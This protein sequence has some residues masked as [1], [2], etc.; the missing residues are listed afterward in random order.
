MI[1]TWY[2]NPRFSL[3]VKFLLVTEYCSTIKISDN[4][5]KKIIRK[6]ANQIWLFD[7]LQLPVACKY[8][9]NVALSNL[10]HCTFI[11]PLQLHIEICKFKYITLLITFFLEFGNKKSD[12]IFSRQLYAVAI[13]QAWTTAETWIIASKYVYTIL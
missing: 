6:F 1:Y 13:I 11:C 7:V 10:W 4:D 9:P 12:G 8:Q 5:L 3:A 2:G